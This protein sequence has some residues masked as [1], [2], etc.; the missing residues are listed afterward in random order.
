MSSLDQKETRFFSEN[1]I[2]IIPHS[3]NSTKFGTSTQFRG[4][5]N[6]LANIPANSLRSHGDRLQPVVN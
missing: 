5:L 4:L 1:S 3:T 6:F 2:F